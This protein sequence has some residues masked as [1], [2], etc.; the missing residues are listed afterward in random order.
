MV[1]LSAVMAV[2][3]A[4]ARVEVGGLRTE[5]LDN[6]L[7]LDVAAPRFSW[8]MNSDKKNVRQKAYRIL[9]ASS[10]EL[11]EQDKGDLWDS[12]RVGSADQLWI[13]YGGKALKSNQRGWWKVRVETDRDGSAWSTPASFGIGLLG[14]TRWG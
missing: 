13:S 6:P 7:G 8:Q 1:L 12:G 10:P 11:L 2:S 9:V 5:N 4:S 3:G 14:E